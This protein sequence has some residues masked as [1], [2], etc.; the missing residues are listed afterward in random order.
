MRRRASE[1]LGL[2]LAVMLLPIAGHA[3]TETYVR[4]ETRAGVSQSFMLIEAAKPQAAAVL[5]AGG[6]GRLKLSPAGYGALRNN[7][8]VRS[9]QL[10]AENGMLVAVVDAAS[11]FQGEDGL[12]GER[13]GKR[14]AAD[15]SAVIAYLRTKARVPVWVIGT[16]RGTLSAANAA[17]RLGSEGPAGVILT[18]TVTQASKRRPSSV[19]D[20]KLD[21]IRAPV[22]LVHHK[23]D[24]CA[25]SPYAGLAALTKKLKRAAKVE[26]LAFDGG[27]RPR[28][29]PCEA[30]SYHGFLG[31]ER[32]VVE[33]IVAWTRR[34]PLSADSS[35]RMP[36]RFPQSVSEPVLTGSVPNPRR[37]S[38]MT[39]ACPQRVLPSHQ[40]LITPSASASMSVNSRLRVALSPC[41]TSSRTPSAASAPA[42]ATQRRRG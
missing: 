19:Y 25:V 27:D 26:T 21:A 29:E 24:E 38:R 39:R 42:S 13:A 41:S 40:P 9:R 23:R 16:S 8:L 12:D 22:L 20:V 6:N 14:H 18:A 17:A 3:Q 5:F 4:I 11:D 30:L 2:V 1:R 28:S 34:T 35:R 33:A 36:R 10:F 31:R 15:V 37:R 32:E 7:F